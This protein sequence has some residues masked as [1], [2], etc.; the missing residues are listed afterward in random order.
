MTSAG[1]AFQTRAPAT[2]K[3]RRPTAG[4]L[5]AGTQTATPQPTH[6][7]SNRPLQHMKQVLTRLSLRNLC[8][9]MFA[10]YS[11]SNCRVTL[12]LEFG[13]LK[14]IGRKWYHSVA[15]VWFPVRLYIA[16]MAV[17]RTVSEI[18]RLIGSKSLNFL[19]PSLYSAPPLGVKPSELSNNP[20]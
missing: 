1:R 7:T 12:K 13:S 8:D 18:H 17:S 10:R 2:E 16:N 5:T 14:V 20:R 9:V 6:S 3:A 15:G 4:S 11:H 19:I